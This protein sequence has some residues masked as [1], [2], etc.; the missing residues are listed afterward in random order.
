MRGSVTNLLTAVILR[1]AF[2]CL[3]VLFFVSLSTL[4]PHDNNIGGGLEGVVP[5]REVGK[6]QLVE[7]SL[8]EFW[9]LPVL[10]V[11][12]EFGENLDGGFLGL[13]NRLL[14]GVDGEAAPSHH[15][16]HLPSNLTES[17][18]PEVITS[19]TLFEFVQK[20]ETISF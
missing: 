9:V 10:E 19:Y 4:V 6:Y 15:G 2:P 14:R 16:L 11:N 7:C 17:R 13:G 18:P 3:S 8:Q 20:R 1:L 5:L 12:L